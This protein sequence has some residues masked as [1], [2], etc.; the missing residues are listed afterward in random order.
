MHIRKGTMDAMMTAKRD[1]W[2]GTSCSKTSCA[3]AF[4]CAHRTLSSDFTREVDG[5]L[6]L[7]R[8]PISLAT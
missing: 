4:L 5:V 6:R 2:V 1:V 8:H 3:K 7:G